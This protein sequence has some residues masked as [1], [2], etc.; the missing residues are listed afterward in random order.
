M[1]KG[2]PCKNGFTTVQSICTSTFY[3]NSN[4]VQCGDSLKKFTLPS[5]EH[6]EDANALDFIGNIY[7]AIAKATACKLHSSVRR[8]MLI[9]SV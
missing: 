4:A 2:E 5:D 1:H 9:N 6:K 3:P 7:E 8:N